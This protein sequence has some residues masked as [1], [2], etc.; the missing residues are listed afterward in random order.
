MAD[1]RMQIPASDFIADVSLA[2][3]FI[4]KGKSIIWDRS[5]AA[6]QECEGGCHAGGTET[7][8]M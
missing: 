2:N 8:E 5:V 4:V 3:R 6:M 1:M 7:Q